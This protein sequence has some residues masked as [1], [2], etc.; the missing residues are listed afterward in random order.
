M[1]ALGYSLSIALG[2]GLLVF[3]W[4]NQEAFIPVYLPW[5]SYPAAALWKIVLVAVATGALFTGIFAVPEGAHRIF[6]T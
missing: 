5:A 4:T 3:F 6:Q 2:F 1:R